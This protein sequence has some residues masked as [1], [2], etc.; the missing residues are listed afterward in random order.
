MPELF[1]STP[2]KMAESLT[3]QSAQHSGNDWTTE[4]TLNSAVG[5]AL[6]TLIVFM[7][8]QSL[9]TDMPSL[10]TSSLWRDRGINPNFHQVMQEAR[11]G[12]A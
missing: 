10:Q 12:T 1:Q 3:A 9:I 6:L 2:E 4:L 8:Q 7:L 5:A 11:T